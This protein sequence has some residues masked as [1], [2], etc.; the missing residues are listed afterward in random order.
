MWCEV[1]GV[2]WLLV[3]VE[4]GCCVCFFKGET[5]LRFTVGLEFRQGLFRSFVVGGGVCNKRR[6][7][8][9]LRKYPQ[10]EER[11]I[12]KLGRWEERRVGKGGR[13]RWSPYHRKKKRKY[14]A[15]SVIRGV[16]IAHI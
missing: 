13:S 3:Q 14:K 2:W 4:E 10:V 7:M 16:H 11:V 5:A 15:S 6:D 9:I 8:G 12:V 1:V